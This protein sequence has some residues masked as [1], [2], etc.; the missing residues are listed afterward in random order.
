M[1]GL[2]QERLQAAIAG[3][4][5]QRLAL[6]DAVVDAGIAALQAKSTRC[7]RTRPGRSC[8]WSACCSPMSLVPP[9]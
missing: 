4:Q 9:R 2:E 6:G 3:L 5:A 7:A 8:A 1:S